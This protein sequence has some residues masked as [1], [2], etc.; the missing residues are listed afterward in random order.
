MG[1][2]HG[3]A[4]D[5]YRWVERGL[6][7]GWGSDKD[8]AV[9][10]ER[11]NLQRRRGDVVCFCGGAVSAREVKVPERTNS[12]RGEG[13]GVWG[14]GFVDGEAAKTMRMDMGAT[15]RHKSNVLIMRQMV[16]RTVWLVII[17][18]FIPAHVISP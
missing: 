1:G 5:L 7:L 4:C 12:R 17:Q 6:Q 15:V 16:D 8:L 2:G 13:K 9:L 11:H 3:C 18:Q 10:G 14:F